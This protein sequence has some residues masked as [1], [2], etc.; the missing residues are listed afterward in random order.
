MAD[1]FSIAPDPIPAP[2]IAAQSSYPPDV[3]AMILARAQQ[4]APQLAPQVPQAV[5]QPLGEKVGTLGIE[6]FNPVV[7]DV[8]QQYPGLAPY[9][10]NLAIQRGTTTNPNDDRQLEFYQPWDSDNPNPGKITSELYNKKLK[11]QDLTET[12]A[13]DMLHH[14]GTVDPATGKPINP[15]WMAMKQ[16]MI[17]GMGPDQDSMNKEAYQQEKSNPA[18]ETGPYDQWMK[19]NRSDAF[20]RGAL[21]PNQNP[22]WQQSGMYTPAM[23]KAAAAM[24][25]YLKNGDN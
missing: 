7:K 12:I 10:K 6:D 22:E 5:P 3:M 18:Y 4:S 2:D 11:G 21:F 9:T 20:I 24:R 23:Q 15:K 14:L 1:P 25:L 13:G 19:N 17:D 16:Q 8:A